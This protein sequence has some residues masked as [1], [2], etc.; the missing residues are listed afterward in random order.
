M[1]QDSGNW[2]T[3]QIGVAAIAGAAVDWYL[4]WLV[5][6]DAKFVTVL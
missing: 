6:W 1:S 4:P 5:D 3:C 2:C